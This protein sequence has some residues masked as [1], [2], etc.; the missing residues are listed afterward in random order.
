MVAAQNETDHTEFMLTD[1]MIREGLADALAAYDQ[2]SLDGLNVYFA[3]K[4]AV[5]AGCKVVHSGEGGDELFVGYNQL[6]KPRMA[7]KW[8]P[9]FRWLPKWVGDALS[10]H[11]GAEKVRKLAQMFGC[12]YDPY[13]LTRRQFSPA[14]IAR[15]LARNMQPD[16]VKLYADQMVAVDTLGIDI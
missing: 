12:R 11:G 2:P 16:L 15:L 13:F 7:Y 9:W 1:A 10:I 5:G 8:T 3:S 4:F 14:W 6:S